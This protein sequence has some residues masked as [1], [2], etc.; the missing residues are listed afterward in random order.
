MIEQMNLKS[1]NE[2]VNSN[3]GCQIHFDSFDFFFAHL[4]ILT[5]ELS[6]KLNITH[7]PKFQIKILN[8]I[9]S[10]R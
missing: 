6:Y 2:N 7:H 5:L 3:N 8:S 4:R 9:L 10:R 1:W